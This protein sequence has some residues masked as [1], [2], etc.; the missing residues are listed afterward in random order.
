MTRKYTYKGKQL[1]VKELVALS[2]NVGYDTMLNRLRQGW[3]IDDAINTPL[4]S[5]PTKTKIDLLETIPRADTFNNIE[6]N[7]QDKAI[8]TGLI[9]D[10]FKT[11]QRGMELLEQKKDPKQKA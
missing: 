4:H 10:Y 3:K 11:K 8:I 9:A 1:T 6:L 2:D 5:R 7:K